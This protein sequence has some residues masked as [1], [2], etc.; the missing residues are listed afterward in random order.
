MTDEQMR[1]R[2]RIEG[3][4]RSLREVYD[5]T[6]GHHAFAQRDPISSMETVAFFLRHDLSDV[7]ELLIHLK[8]EL[9]E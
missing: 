3:A 7:I 8:G 1:S 5:A 6:H 4:L 2:V 9:S